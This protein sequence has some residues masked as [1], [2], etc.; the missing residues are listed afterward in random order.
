MLVAIEVGR[1]VVGGD[2]DVQAAIAIEIAKGQAAGH[3]GG[4]E[5]AA[6]PRRATSRKAAVA[7][8]EE[9]V[10]RLRVTPLP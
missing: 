4:G 2:Q 6:R 5:T 1:A 3:F 9:Q 10:R 8:V 7:I